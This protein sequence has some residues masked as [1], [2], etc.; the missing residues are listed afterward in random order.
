MRNMWPSE[1]RAHQL[2]GKAARQ[3]ATLPRPEFNALIAYASKFF[4]SNAIYNAVFVRVMA[5]YGVDASGADYLWGRL[6]GT[7]GRISFDEFC[8]AVSKI[9]LIRLEGIKVTPGHKMILSRR[10]R[11]KTRI[12]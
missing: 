10:K 1:W 3:P 4:Q 2:Y 6:F 7:R 9:G 8:Y 5:H 11:R 12:P